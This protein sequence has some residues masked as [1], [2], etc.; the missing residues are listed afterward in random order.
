MSRRACPFLRQL[1]IVVSLELLAVAAMAG[2]V[3]QAVV[4]MPETQRALFTE[5]CVK[6]HNAEKSKG[7]VRLDDLPV[8]IKSIEMAERWQKV[9]NVLNAGEMPPEDEAQPS[10]AEKTAFLDTLSNTMVA[11][12]RALGDSGGVATMRRL[13]RREYVHTIRDLLGVTLDAIDLPSDASPGGFDTVGSS[14]FLSADQFE[15]YL[16]LARSALDEA[17]VA[18]DRPRPKSTI[19]RTEV[20]TAANAAVQQQLDSMRERYVRARQWEAT[21]GQKSWT[22]FGFDTD[23]DVRLILGSFPARSPAYALYLTDPLTREGA[24]L[25]GYLPNMFVRVT[26]PRD[27]PRGRYLLRVRIARTSKYV[28]AERSFVEMGYPSGNET[29][30]L[31]TYQVTGTLEE[32]QTLELPVTVRNARTF[33]FCEKAHQ[34]GLARSRAFFKVAEKNHIGP[35]PAL[36][37]DWVEVEGPLCETWPPKSHQ[38]IFFKGAV[39]EAAKNDAYAR[40]IIA[41]FAHRAQRGREPADALLD[42]LVALYQERRRQG[43]G[44]EAALKEPLAVVLASPS[45]L[46]LAEPAGDDDNSQPVAA[47]DEAGRPVALAPIELANRL[48]Y[49]LWSAPPDDELLV[50]A[51]EGRLADPAGLR[52]QVERMLR[53]PKAYDFVVGFTSQWLGMERLEFFDFDDVRYPLFD[54]SVKLAA[55][56][57]VYR[58]VHTVL[59]ENLSVRR[60]LKSDFVVVN[61][62]LANYY[63]L[64]GVSGDE[65]RKVPLPADSK[66]GGLLGMAAV[67]AMGS[68]G[69]RTSPVERGVW[70][71]RKLLNQPPPPA[72]PN[73]PQLSRLSANRIFSARELLA[74]HQEQAQCAQCHR[75]I[76]PIGFAL[77]NFDAVGIWRTEETIE[78]TTPRLAQSPP[79][80]LQSKSFP[81]DAS[82]RM[83]DG[84]PISGYDGLRDLVAGRLDGFAR[85]LVE[86]LAVYG[87]GRPLSFSDEPFLKSV[88]AET[89]GDGYRLADLIQ[90]IVRNRKFQTKTG[91]SAA[92]LQAE[93]SATAGSGRRSTSGGP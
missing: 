93:N 38:E 73:V 17:I 56:D 33:A 79:K 54:A 89:K 12:R 23:F 52:R 57:E 62:L 43:D 13:N 31:G 58:T 3:N 45:F 15:Q 91:S 59:N 74:A 22:D 70:V 88:L 63:G 60:L 86:A 30:I 68:D 1:G 21:K 35:D 10:N 61:S 80:V 6:C 29:T 7:Q 64:E 47:G 82:G 27:S 14:L 48:S 55:R 67:L 72:P 77:E 49:F 28:P 9:L 51:R 83:S 66:R 11:A 16:A 78:L 25:T 53:D 87:L 84:T 40:E 36:W 46:Y 42:R 24:F 34:S 5:Y 41:R 76:D 81:I 26:I 19:V 92:L 44:F 75:K 50:V 18:A 8:Q 39:D 90:A 71:L 4:A 69:E 2:D 20:E 65:F 32:P 37:I 85:G